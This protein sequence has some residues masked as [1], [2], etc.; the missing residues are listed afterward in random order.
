MFN[1]FKLEEKDILVWRGLS[2][3][4]CSQSTQGRAGLAGVW[5]PGY[6]PVIPPHIHFQTL[7]TLAVLLLL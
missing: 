6:K 3:S 5:L 7:L 4:E 2:R 1:I